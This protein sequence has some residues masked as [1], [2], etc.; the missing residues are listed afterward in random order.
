M[1]KQETKINYYVNLLWWP[2]L[3]ALVFEVAS[4]FTANADSLILA[5]DIIL[6]FYLL[7]KTKVSDYKLAIW[8]N[9]LIIFFIALAVAIVEF[10]I[11]LKFYNLFNIIVE[12]IIYGSGAALMSSCLILILNKFKL[13]PLAGGVKKG[14]EE[15]GR[16]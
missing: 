16:K 3:L 12:P 2:I 7:V 15:H 11:N 10:L 14:G 13:R 1:I 6:I 8:L 9:G 4:L 5:A